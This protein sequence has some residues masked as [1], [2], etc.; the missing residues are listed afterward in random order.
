MIQPL[1][2]QTLPPHPL[3]RFQPR[4]RGRARLR[5]VQ[6]S[7]R[8]GSIVV[9]PAGYVMEYARDHPLAQASCRVEQHRLVMEC[10]LGRLLTHQEIVHHKNRVRHDNRAENLQVLTR[11]EHGQEHAPELRKRFLVPLTEQQ[12]R[13]ALQVRTTAEAANLLGVHHMTLRNR[14]DHLLTKRISPGAPYPEAF[15]KRVRQLAAD[16]LGPTG[17]PSRSA[18]KSDDR[19]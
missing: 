4:G 9:T 13:E 2:D 10:V 8:G 17:R 14:F 6:P 5:P 15:V 7:C 16:W 11:P 12:V 18:S 3:G 19:Q 1:L